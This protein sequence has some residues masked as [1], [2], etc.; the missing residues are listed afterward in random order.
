[1]LPVA[2]H[3][4]RKPLNGLAIDLDDTALPRL[5]WKNSQKFSSAKKICAWHPVR[6]FAQDL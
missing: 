2:G 4:G 3:A 5:K 1:V 6:S